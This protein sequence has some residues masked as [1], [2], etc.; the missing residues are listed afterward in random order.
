MSDRNFFLS[1]TLTLRFFQ[2]LCLLRQYLEKENP[3]ETR[4]KLAAVANFKDATG[5][6][7]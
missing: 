7:E 6:F 4:E 2:C 5:R 3:E 1:A